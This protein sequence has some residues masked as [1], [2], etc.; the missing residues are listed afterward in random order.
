MCILNEEAYNIYFI[1]LFYSTIK[2]IT[3]EA[4]LSFLVY[5]NGKKQSHP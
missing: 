5:E 2:S 3:I 4:I 1:R